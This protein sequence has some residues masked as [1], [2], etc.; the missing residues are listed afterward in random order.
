MILGSLFQN[1]AVLQR[2][3]NI[4]VWGR[5]LPNRKVEALLDGNRAQTHSSADGFFILYLPAHDA[6]GPFELTVEVKNSE[7]EKIVLND[8]LIGEVW[9][10]S[11]QSNMAYK[12]NSDWRVNTDLPADK[13]V[14]RVQERQ[15]NEMVM[16]SEKFR[17]FNVAER[18]SMTR[19]EF[20]A[21]T[22]N[23]MDKTHLG[24]SSAVAAWFGLGLQ[25]QLENV[26][27]GIIN[28]SWG[29]SVAEAWMS[30]ESLWSS[31]ETRKIALEME[32]LCSDPGPWDASGAASFENNPDVHADPGNTGIAMGYA[33]CSFD[34]SSWQDMTIGGSWIK[35]QIA[36]NGVIWVRKRVEIPE[37]WSGCD[38]TLQGG[39]VDKQ[40]ITYFNGTEIGRMGKGFETCYYN[41]ARVY[42]IPANLVK[43]GAAVVAIRAYS[44]SHDG[45]VAG[46]W[47]LVN[48]KTGE[49]IDLC[50]SWKAKA[51]Y[52]WG[53][54]RTNDPAYT[55]GPGNPTRTPTTMFNGLINPLLPYAMR[56]VIWYQG[57]SNAN[58]VAS[59]RAY[60]DILQTMIDD[61]RVKLHNPQMP[62][63]QVQLAGFNTEAEKFAWAELRES[64]RIL[65]LND[66]DIFMAS[67]IDIG[68][69]EDIHPENKLD[70]GKRL[71]MCALHHVYGCEELIPSGP[72]I[73]GAA[74][75]G[76]GV[77][78][79]FN[80]AE[81]L[82]LTSEERSF[83]IAGN[84]GIYHPAET[85]LINE[86]DN[87]LLIA[88]TA[89]KSPCRVRY[90]WANDPVPILY[91][92][93]GFPASS[94]EITLD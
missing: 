77:R 43:S 23:K 44:F 94:F 4:P 74:V 87:T 67:A 33:D 1:G 53:V 9:L 79:S 10:A 72:E 19:E 51:E 81:K 47:N 71:A 20:C 42:P 27:I 85:M 41:V 2:G 57:E 90:A 29:G 75:E 14:G 31:P 58:T 15:F 82:H 60:R 28:A 32:K 30:M 84:D 73:S 39:R 55:F 7:G 91:N 35:Q 36:G 92:G 25:Y 54:V 63:L 86:D 49:S 89:V 18:S 48:N 24:E 56:G 80:Y 22:W 61:W 46:S 66:P 26:P 17:F 88:S 68:E 34:D 3:R 70:V 52:D 65:A 21:G 78:L 11:G 37:S 38:L 76:D 64:Q 8:I 69:K 45:S 13:A 5:T 83:E 40:D 50:G 16:D 6:G 93:A 12:L 62:F 59:A